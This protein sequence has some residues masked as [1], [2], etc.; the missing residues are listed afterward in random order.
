MTFSDVSEVL[1]ASAPIV[2][3]ITGVITV[4]LGRT[5]HTLVNSAM[6]AVK[7]DLALANARIVA[8]QTIVKDLQATN[9]IPPPLMIPPPI[10]PTVAKV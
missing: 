10:P 9:L 5:I 3:A 8:L 1:K 7:A 4:Y 6:T 2:A